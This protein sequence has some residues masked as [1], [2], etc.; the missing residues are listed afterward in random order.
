[1]SSLIKFK[2]GVEF[3]NALLKDA[4]VDFAEGVALRIARRLSNCLYCQ[5]RFIMRDNR[6]LY[7]CVKCKQAEY[8]KRRDN[9]KNDPSN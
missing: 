4:S 9:E 7:C 5:R 8:R 3:A 6:Q 2:N 1:M